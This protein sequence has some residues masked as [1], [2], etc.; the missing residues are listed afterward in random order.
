VVDA[1]LPKLEERI[2]HSEGKLR[3]DAAQDKLL[4]LGFTGRADDTVTA[5]GQFLVS[6]DTIA[7]Q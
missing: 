2:E 6:L 7:H 5:P 4:A 1:F 3:A